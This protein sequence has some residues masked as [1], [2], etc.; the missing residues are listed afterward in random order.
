[1]AEVTI[2]QAGVADC[3]ALADLCAEDAAFER[4]PAP[5]VDQCARLSRL[6]AG[7]E[8]RVW[9]ARSP[10]AVIG[11]ASGEPAISTW[12]AERYWHLDT[13]FVRPAWRGQGIGEALLR[14]VLDHAAGAG[15]GWAEWQTPTWNAAAARFYLRCAAQETRKRRFRM[16]IAPSQARRNAPR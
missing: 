7:D 5:P 16:T 11:Y 15:P 1:V 8:F 9:V 14:R 3:A 10:Q 2:E 13:L 4:A 6:L 12:Q